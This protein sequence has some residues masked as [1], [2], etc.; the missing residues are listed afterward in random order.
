[1]RGIDASPWVREWEHGRHCS[2]RIEEGE[3]SAAE[4][5]EWI[6]R[7]EKYA[8]EDGYCDGRRWRHDGWTEGCW[9]RSVTITI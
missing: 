9:N 7:G 6:Y 2:V 5:D 4:R 1:M 8:V 3:V